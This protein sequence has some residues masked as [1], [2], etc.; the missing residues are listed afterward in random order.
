MQQPHITK[1]AR[2]LD[3]ALDQS[4]VGSFRNT[5]GFLADPTRE[6]SRHINDA[7]GSRG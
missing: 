4:L 2:E 1:L 3:K 5:S 6:F 7:A